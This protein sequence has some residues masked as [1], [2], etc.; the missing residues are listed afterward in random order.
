MMMICNFAYII[1]NGVLPIP[2]YAVLKLLENSKLFAN[3]VEADAGT[4]AQGTKNSLRALRVNPA[5]SRRDVKSPQST[6]I[7]SIFV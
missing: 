1:G 2:P 5:D 7:V 3:D 6:T 4:G